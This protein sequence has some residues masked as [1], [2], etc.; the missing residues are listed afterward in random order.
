M[1]CIALDSAALL[2]EDHHECSRLAHPL[3][4]S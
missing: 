2:T 4:A 1:T 3:L